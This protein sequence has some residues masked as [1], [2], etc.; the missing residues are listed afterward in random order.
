MHKNI[1]EAIA[2]GDVTRVIAIVDPAFK[3]AAREASER[4]H[5]KGIPVSDGRANQSGGRTDDGA[6]QSSQAD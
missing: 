1:F 5:A 4:A 6:A 3:K 2:T